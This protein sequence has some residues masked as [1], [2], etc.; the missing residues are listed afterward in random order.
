[1]YLQTSRNF[2]KKIGITIDCL[3]STLL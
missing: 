2:K 1:M 3:R